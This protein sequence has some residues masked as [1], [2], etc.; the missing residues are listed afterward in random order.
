M[1][2][3]SRLIG[4]FSEIITLRNL[5]LSGALNDDQLEVIKDAG[6]VVKDDIIHQIG[7]FTSL[8]KSNPQIPLEEITSPSVLMP[9]LIDA[10]THICFAGSRSEDYAMR[11]AGKSYLAI[12]K[13]GGGILNTVLATRNATKFELTTNLIHR[14][15]ELLAR[16][17]TTCEVKSGYGLTVD[18]EL[19]ML[20]TIKEVDNMLALTLI[21]TCLA[22]H[23]LPPEFKSP[24]DY[25]NMCVN[26][27]LPRVKEEKLASRVDIFV[28]ESAFNSSDAKVYLE[29]A[30]A[31]GFDITVHADQFSTKG[32]E[33][34]ATMKAISA[35]HLE[36]STEK[37][38]DILAKASVTGILLPGA[39]MGLGM[40]YPKGRLMLDRGM[41]IAI[42]SDWNPGSAPMGNL[43]MQA[44]VFG[45]YAKLSTA[46][47]LA[48]ITFRAA[49]ALKLFD[50]GTLEVD[51]RADMIGFPCKD[52]REILYNQG[53]MKPEHIWIAG[54]KYSSNII[55]H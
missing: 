8:I 53:N 52:Y 30:K 3:N 45:A 41:C 34:A 31:M 51:K 18:A 26:Q 36:A 40:N 20:S 49:H 48:A 27:L 32:S 46:E 25:L 16:G 23:T 33:L 29:A 39:S 47:T 35:D 50:R 15:K 9:G 14:C 54:Q 6:V 5:P 24:S 21:P 12:A 37:E 2:H 17:V 55:I 7:P 43:L 28:E 22:A 44:S 4:P 19:K 38:I 11:T 10:H 1:I 42:A 13:N